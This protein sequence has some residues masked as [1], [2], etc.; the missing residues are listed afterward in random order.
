LIAFERNG[1]IRLWEIET[2]QERSMDI[3]RAALST[4]LSWSPDG[5]CLTYGITSGLTGKETRFYLYDLQTGR[6]NELP[7]RY[8]S[9]LLIAS[10][11]GYM[12]GEDSDS[13]GLS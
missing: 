4:N 13:G 11:S 5:Q 9:G 10:I 7:L 2:G 3:G 1:S 6:R 8:A 12:Q